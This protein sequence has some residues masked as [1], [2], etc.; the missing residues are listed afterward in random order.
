MYITSYPR[1]SQAS[2]NKFNIPIPKIRGG[3]TTTNAVF[4]HDPSF[5]TH[6]DLSQVMF[7]VQPPVPGNSDAPVAVATEVM[8]VGLLLAELESGNPY[9]D[10]EEN[11][12]PGFQLPPLDLDLLYMTLENEPVAEPTAEE[13]AAYFF[14][15]N[16][17][18]K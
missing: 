18:G 2:S 6:N 16:T 7:Q 8:P 4:E 14:L 13:I 9:I 17:L 5:P 15:N 11:F 3:S 10:S 12:H 1:N